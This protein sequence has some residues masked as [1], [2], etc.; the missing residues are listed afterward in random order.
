MLT[1]GIFMPILAQAYNSVTIVM[2][3]PTPANLAFIDQ[4]KTELANTKNNNLSVKV[5]ELPE[6]GR[7]VVAENSE[8]VIALGTKALEEASKLKHST[9]VMGVF[10]P[11]PTFNSVLVKSH[12]DRGN[13]SAIVLDQP[14][15]RQMTLIKI[16]LPELNKLGVLL[17]PISSQYGAKIKENAEDS[18]YSIFEENIKQEADL[19]PKLKQLLDVSEALM[20]IPD[21]HIYTRETAQP[22]ILTSYRYQKPIFGYSQSY[23]RAGAL[24]AVYSSSKQLAQQAAEI[25][26]KSQQAPSMLPPLQAPKYFSIMVNYQVGR[27]LNIPLM[28]ESVIYKKMLEAEPT[29]LEEYE[30]I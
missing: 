8:L 24:A 20:A 23:V 26:I 30:P 19:M 18:G 25:A 9:P 29:E 10:I 13:F 22:I 4:F 11:H 17:G 7:L 6:T 5:M 28:E 15:A 21:P 12:R 3:A 14:F 1:L 16:V 27:S 2:S